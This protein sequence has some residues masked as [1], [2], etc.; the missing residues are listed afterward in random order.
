MPQ[1]MSGTGWQVQDELYKGVLHPV[2]SEFFISV[3]GAGQ[4]PAI[5]RHCPFSC[6]GQ[7]C[8]TGRSHVQYDFAC[9]FPVVHHAAAVKK[10]CSISEYLLVA[11]G[12]KSGLPNQ[13]TS[14]E[15]GPLRAMVIKVS[16]AGDSQLL[17]EMI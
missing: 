10:T 3:S 7:E 4:G 9:R 17:S 13:M 2:F 5:K 12:L 11:T 8:N 6:K 15:C 16:Q 14:A 1:A